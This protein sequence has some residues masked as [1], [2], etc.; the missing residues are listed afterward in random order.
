MLDK[1]LIVQSDNN[2]ETPILCSLLI[3]RMKFLYMSIAPNQ[4]FYLKVSLQTSKLYRKAAIWCNL[5]DYK[6]NK[7]T[8][9]HTGKLLFA[10]NFRM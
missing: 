10:C 5:C 7:Y 1:H 8:V 9:I 3:E 4:V 2:L 6:A